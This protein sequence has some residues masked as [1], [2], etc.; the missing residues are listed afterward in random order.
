MDRLKKYKNEIV[1][2]ESIKKFVQKNKI[3]CSSIDI[4]IQKAESILSLMKKLNINE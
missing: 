3:D 4:K 2:Y 1:K